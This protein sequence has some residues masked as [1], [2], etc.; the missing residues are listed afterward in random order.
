MIDRVRIPT[1]TSEDGVGDFEREDFVRGSANFGAGGIEATL[2]QLSKWIVSALF[3]ALIL[4]RHDAET[5][6]AAVG[7]ALNNTLSVAL[8][9]ILNQERP[10]ST[11]RADPGMP[12]SHA[13]SIFYAVAFANMSMVECYGINALT[14]TLCGLVFVIG[15]YFS[16][17]RVSQ[18]FHTISQVLVGAVLGST[19]SIFWYWSW[20]AFVLKAFVSYLWVRILI[21]LGCIGYII[22]FIVFCFV[23]SIMRE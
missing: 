10:I 14:A 13:Q 20:N 23:D 1:S 8:K 7:V 22:G 12:S 11:L 16:W 6:W 18:Q 9:F 17:L 5:M 3:M 15:S 2:N 4:W 19:F 21:V